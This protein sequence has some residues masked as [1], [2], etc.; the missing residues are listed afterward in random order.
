MEVSNF[1]LPSPIS[2]FPYPLPLAITN[3]FSKSIRSVFEAF[4]FNI[5]Y[6]YTIALIA[7]ASKVILKTLQGRLQ[8]HVNSE[9]PDVQD[10]FRK[11]RKKMRDQISNICWNI[12][13]ARELI[14]HLL[15]LY[16]LHQSLCVDHN[17][18][19]KILKEIRIP[20]LPVS[21]ETCKQDKKQQLE[22]HMEQQTGSKLGKEY[23]KAAYGHPAYLHFMQSISCEMPGWMNHKLELRLT[24][25]IPVTS[26]MQM[27]P[28]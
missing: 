22:P 25:E 23:I 1:W 19:W 16:W 4:L 14:R 17:K 15:L 3:M 20:T 6:T 9:L 12:E 18:L 13:K 7:H 27:I 10:G 24:G 28:F 11:T 2:H 8:Q 21:W 5:S 26:D